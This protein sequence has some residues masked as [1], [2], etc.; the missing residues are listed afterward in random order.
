MNIPAKLCLKNDK[1]LKNGGERYCREL[2][3]RNLYQQV[4]NIY[5][6]DIDYSLKTEIIR[7]FFATV[8]NKM[9]YATHKKRQQNWY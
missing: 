6:T 2:L 4:S 7:E 9:H 1:H 5:A 8:Q 3:Q